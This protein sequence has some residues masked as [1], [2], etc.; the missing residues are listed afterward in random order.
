MPYYV[1]MLTDKKN[2]VLYVGVTD[3]LARRVAEHR[4]EMHEGFTKRYHLE[5]LVY[6][7]GWNDINGAIAR[8]KQLKGWRRAKK[9][10]LIR[11]INPRW[12]ELMPKV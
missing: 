5:K 2:N 6:A 8:E 9:D 3:D 1:Y 7:E 12:E 11:E 10:A 4:S